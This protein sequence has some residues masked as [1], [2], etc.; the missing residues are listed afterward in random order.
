MSIKIFHSGNNLLQHLRRRNQKCCVRHK[1]TKSR[2]RRCYFLIFVCN[3]NDFSTTVKIRESSILHIFYCRKYKIANNMKN[4]IR[5]FIFEM[6]PTHRLSYGRRRKYML[7]LFSRYNFSLL[8]LNFIDIQR[9]YEHKISKLFN[10][11]QWICNSTS[12]NMSPNLIHF[13]FD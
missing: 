11:R 2:I 10:N 13:I 3:R 12:P 6:A 8:V 7:P 4:L 1:F 5:I 9:T